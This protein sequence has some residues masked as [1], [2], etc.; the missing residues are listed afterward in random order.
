MNEKGFGLKEFIIV[1]AVIFVSMLIIMS[2]F[3]S[4]SSNTDTNPQSNQEEEREE[5]TYKDLEQELKLAAERYQNDN[6]SGSIENPEV[7]T[8]SYSML[9]ENG[10]LDEI[11]D[12]K[13]K[14]NECT[15]YVE[16][17]QDGGVITYTPYLKCGSNYETEGYDAKN[18]MPK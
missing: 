9:K 8:L 1:I 15:G 14:D 13:N 3:R 6:Y 10:Y 11:K 18:K 4:M 16:F 17:V 2:L 5:V 12:I 7:W